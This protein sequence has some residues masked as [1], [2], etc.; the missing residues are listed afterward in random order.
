[1]RV[2]ALALAILAHGAAVA[3]QIP[4]ARPAGTAPRDAAIAQVVGPA[5]VQEMRLRIARAAF[6]TT[7]EVGELQFPG[8][9]APVEWSALRQHVLTATRSRP[10]TPRD[11]VGW[12]V[13]VGD[14]S[15]SGNT[16]RGRFSIGARWVC[17]GKGSSGNKE[18][19]EPKATRAAGGPWSP[20]EIRTTELS[21]GLSCAARL[22]WGG[23]GA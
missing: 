18:S 17:P 13:R 4:A 10:A 1:M 9:E 19:F 22:E 6:D 11:S 8:R 23:G 12:F 16:L 21:E 20:P 15:I 14:A 3:A 7:I 5:L 2:A